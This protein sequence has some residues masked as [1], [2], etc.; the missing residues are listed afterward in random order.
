MGLLTFNSIIRLNN[1]EIKSTMISKTFFNIFDNQ[2]EHK[3]MDNGPEFIFNSLFTFTNV[4]AGQIDTIDG[5]LRLVF[6]E[7]E[8][9]INEKGKTIVKLDY[10]PLER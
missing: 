8:V 9:S 1:K 10:H 2:Q 3:F 4:T 6:Y 7:K 5:N